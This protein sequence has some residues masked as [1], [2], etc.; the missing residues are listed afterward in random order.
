MS[1]VRAIN[2][3]NKFMKGCILRYL[4]CTDDKHKQVLRYVNV[5]TFKNNA[6]SMMV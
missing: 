1:N 6:I 4:C 3:N 5:K 2:L